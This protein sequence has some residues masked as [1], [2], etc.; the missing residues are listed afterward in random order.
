MRAPTPQ[1]W[2]LPLC[3]IATAFVLGWWIGEYPGWGFPFALFG[4]MFGSE[5]AMYASL[6]LTTLGIAVL[7]AFSTR[8]LWPDAWMRSVTAIAT[9]LTLGSGVWRGGAASTRA[10]NECVREADGVHE[11]IVAFKT[12]NGRYPDDLGELSGKVPCQRPL[13]GS[14]LS[15][16]TT[17]TGFTLEFHDWLV[18]HEGNEQHGM[19][20]SQ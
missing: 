7:V 5:T 15:Y 1:A 20:A 11:Q 13:R 18:T 17:G 6:A 9:A 4:L 14:L 2:L 3:T 10:F 19:H 16:A 12:A 8:R